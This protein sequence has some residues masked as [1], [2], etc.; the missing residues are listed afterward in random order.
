MSTEHPILKNLTPG[1]PVSLCTVV[2]FP[3]AGG[4]A[5][6][7]RGWQRQLSPLVNAFAVQLPGREERLS[8]APESDAERVVAELC[9]AIEPV[10]TSKVI[11]FGHSLGAVLA[12]RVAQELLG[13]RIESDA[14]LF[15]SGRRS[16]W[17]GPVSS[18]AR[19]L[20][21]SELLERLRSEGGPRAE[22]ASNG[23]FAQLMLPALKADLHLSDAAHGIREQGVRIPVIGLY[24]RHDEGTPPSYVRP[25]SRFTTGGFRSVEIDGDHFFVETKASDVVEI[26]DATAR[27]LIGL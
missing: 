27:S 20:A 18:E 24:G 25:W 22:L 2:C 14:V 16:P 21:D 11:L 15:V 26:V 5:R 1:R 6:V 17:S 12:A 9:T 8:E 3:Y 23:E 13:D 7:F 19:G 10:A 4:G